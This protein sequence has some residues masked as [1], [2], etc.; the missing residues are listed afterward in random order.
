MVVWAVVVERWTGQARAGTVVGEVMPVARF[1]S[2]RLH[3]VGAAD[4][5]LPTGCRPVGPA[6]AACQGW[7]NPSGG[8]SRLPLCRSHLS[9]HQGEK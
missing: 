5:V 6:R 9:P 3:R 4:G 2:T 7:L 8:P 1:A